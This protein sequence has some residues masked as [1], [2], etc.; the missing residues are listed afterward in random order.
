MPRTL[1]M[2]FGRPC[3]LPNSIA[4]LDLPSGQ[5]LE[6]LS[7]LGGSFRSMSILDPPDT[8]CF[9]TA[10]MYVFPRPWFTKLTF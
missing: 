8:V 3:M 10:T 1:S 5:S 9:F 2:T 7:L 4:K 6:R